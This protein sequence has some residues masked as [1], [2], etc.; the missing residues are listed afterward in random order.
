M[1]DVTGLDFA[2]SGAQHLHQLELHVAAKERVG[3]AA[4]ADGQASLVLRLLAGLVRPTSGAITIDG[5]DLTRD[6]FSVRGRVIYVSGDAVPPAPLLVAE[7]IRSIAATRCA[8]APAQLN[9][10]LET[11]ELAPGASIDRL[12]A[13]ERGLVALATAIVVRPRVVLLDSPLRGME[14]QRRSRLM[15][16]ALDELN[17]STVVLASDEPSD[18][19]L[20]QR[21]LRI[22]D[23]QLERG[24]HTART[25]EQMRCAG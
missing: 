8:D 18:L 23:G 3:I 20:C 5:V 21:R 24:S 7:W 16:R 17:E 10:V 4:G 19:A 15:V 14:S 6:P 2:A 9:R 1:I 25:G 11:L 22:V 12:R 13:E